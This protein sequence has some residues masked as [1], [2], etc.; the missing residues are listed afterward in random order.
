MISICKRQSVDC[1][2]A[3]QIFIRQSKF[4]ANLIY[5]QV[6]GQRTDPSAVE[7]IELKQRQ[8]EY[9]LVAKIVSRTVSQ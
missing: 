8:L 5:K 6:A 9:N 3:I 2:R 7:R 1:L 4:Q